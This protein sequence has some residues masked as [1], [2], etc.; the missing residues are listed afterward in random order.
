MGGNRPLVAIGA[1][2]IT[3]IVVAREW[4]LDVWWWLLFALMAMVAGGVWVYRVGRGWGVCLLAVGLCL[5]GAAFSWAESGNQTVIPDERSGR[6]PWT[7]TGI[8]A[9]PPEADGNRGQ[10]TMVVKQAEQTGGRLLDADEPVV[11]QVRF[12]HPGEKEAILA[13]KRGQTIRFPAALKAPDSARNPG[14]FDYRTYLYHR[15]IHWVAVVESGKQVEVLD[16]TPSWRSELDR[17]RHFLGERVE[18]IYPEETAGLV[19]GMLLGE[20]KQVPPVVEENFILL[21]LIHLLAIS[22]LHVGVFV[23]CLFGGLQWCGV[24]RERAVILTML[25]IPFYVLLTGVGAPV[26]RAGTMAALALLAVRLR[27]FS[28]GLSFLAVAAMAML[29]WN[30]YWLFEA[31][32][33]LSFTVTGALLLAVRPLAHV[34]PFPWLRLNQLVA[35]TVTAQMAS[36]PLVLHHFREISLLSGVLNLVVVPVVSVMVIPTAFLALLLSL[37]SDGLAWLPAQFSSTILAWTTAV[38]HPIAAWTESRVV[39][40]PP[41]W[42]WIALYAI[43]CGGLL[44]GI[45]GGPLVRRR[46]LPG[47]LVLI[48]ILGWWVWLP[49]GWSK[50]ELRI[51]FLDVGQGDCAVIETPENRVIVVDGGGTLPFSREDW[52][53]RR[54]DYEV[55]RDVVVPYLKYRGIRRIDELVLSHGDA[56]HIGGIRAVARRFPVKQVIRNGHPPQSGLE[57]ELMEILFSRGASVRVP[58]VGTAWEVEA[59]IHLQFLHPGED[60]GSD[61]NND[62]VVFLL[63]A[64][65]RHILM[66]GDIEE[67]AERQIIRRWELPPLDL[68]KVAHH[69]SRTS[70]GQVWLDHSRPRMAIISAGRN[71]RYGHP[72]PEVVERLQ[73]RDIPLWRTDRDGAVTFIL[74]KSG[75]RVETMVDRK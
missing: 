62:S 28:D 35:V 6:E 37:V 18:A 33:Q 43:T 15:G 21:G 39:V 59:G 51:T 12:D 22:G 58:D 69:G 34:L 41:S 36:L 2:W 45:T 29:I 66:T 50:G 46:M 10:W 40:S 9:A 3:G 25:A 19:R 32:F 20:R 1:G 5:G 17:F 70:T 11:V 13:L 63:T 30:P 68:L 71:N 49:A 73:M 27:Q 55:G 56:D 54:R 26:V 44:G 24:T 72:S 53:Q 61:P 75:W 52:Q 14:A 47:A 7:L 16:P 8:V 74:N 4:A 67:E 57:E 60:L 31:G 42:G 48:L 23:G 65:D 38:I 64:F